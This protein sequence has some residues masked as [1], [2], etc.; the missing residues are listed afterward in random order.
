MSRGVRQLFDRKSKLSFTLISEPSP[1]VLLD[2][3]FS[4]DEYKKVL[5][6][7]E[8]F[9]TGDFTLTCEH[10]LFSMLQDKAWEIFENV[11]PTLDR[12]T[13]GKFKE[14]YEKDG[15]D[16]FFKVMIKRLPPGF[17]RNR[18]HRDAEWKQLVVV[19]Y[20]SDE[21]EG[22]K[23]YAS[24]HVDSLVTTLPFKVNTGYATI[25]N[26]TNWHDFDHSEQFN[27]DRITVMFMMADKR[28]YK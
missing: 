21:G 12:A 17:K 24:E 23:I 9:P 28:Y 14:M 19:I 18:I 16:S 27:K 10:D 6:A 4:D 25:P 5:A 2:S 11:Y 15:R 8:V 22:T 3:P 20:L 26:E 7:A 1:Y 13:D